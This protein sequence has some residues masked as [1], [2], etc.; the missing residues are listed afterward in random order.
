MGEMGLK[1]NWKYFIP[2]KPQDLKCKMLMKNPFEMLNR[3]SQNGSWTCSRHCKVNPA[4]VMVERSLVSVF[5]SVKY[6]K[7]NKAFSI[8]MKIQKLIKKKKQK[9]NFICKFVAN[10]I[11]NLVYK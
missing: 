3:H 2:P 9:W 4:E 1:T 8:L 5:F 6:V 11:S 10:Q 7:L